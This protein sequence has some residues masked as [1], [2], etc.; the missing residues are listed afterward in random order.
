[1][2]VALNLNRIPGIVCCP[3]L[4]IRRHHMQAIWCKIISFGFFIASHVQSR[5]HFCVHTLRRVQSL[6]TAPVNV[7]VLS[8]HTTSVPPAL[9]N[10]SGNMRLI[11]CLLSLSV[12]RRPHSTMTAGTAGGAACTSMSR[13]F[14]TICP[15]DCAKWCALMT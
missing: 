15:V 8:K 14:R 11:P 5:I 12:T 9:I 10:T 3:A 4:P 7:P 1:M 6:T 13:T 2:H